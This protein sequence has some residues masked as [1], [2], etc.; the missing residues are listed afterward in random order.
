LHHFIYGM[1]GRRESITKFLFRLLQSLFDPILVPVR[2]R[3]KDIALKRRYR[4]YHLRGTK[5]E[6][7]LKWNKAGMAFNLHLMKIHFLFLKLF[8]IKEV[9]SL[10]MRLLH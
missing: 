4:I 7:M 10:R 2:I 1:K 5:G 6:S 9:S 8:I 3:V